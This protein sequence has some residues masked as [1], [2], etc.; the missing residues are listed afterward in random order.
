[1]PER[2][3]DVVD[4]QIW[5]HWGLFFSPLHHRAAAHVA[6][7]KH[8]YG[9][10]DVTWPCTLETGY[11]DLTSQWTCRLCDLQT[12]R[13]MQKL[14]HCCVCDHTGRPVNRLHVATF[15]LP[16]PQECGRIMDVVKRPKGRERRSGGCVRNKRQ[17]WMVNDFFHK[18]R[19]PNWATLLYFSGP[20][21]F[22]ESR[23]AV[24]CTSF[25]SED[26]ITLGGEITISLPRLYYTVLS[27][28][29]VTNNTSI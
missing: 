2:G 3:N 4:D 6:T 8:S 22:I 5:C 7:G 10:S 11:F 19:V 18:E 23:S 20:T 21:P 26:S 9:P 25:Q 17:H 29:W 28:N 13:N 27:I 15:V 24:Q 14:N 12:M 16:F 1:M